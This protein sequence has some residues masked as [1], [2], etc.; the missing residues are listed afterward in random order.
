MSTTTCIADDTAAR[1]QF[2]RLPVIEWT[3]IY[4]GTLPGD[5][6]YLG[7]WSDMDN[8]GGINHR[9]VYTACSLGYC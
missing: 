2:P 7:L 6:C 5:S 1:P 3:F 4:K 8:I 9:G